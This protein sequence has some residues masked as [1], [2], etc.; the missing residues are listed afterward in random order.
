MTIIVN[1]RD[2]WPLTNFASARGSNQRL[3]GNKSDTP[4]IELRQ[5]QKVMY[6]EIDKKAI[7]D[8]KQIKALKT[9]P[10]NMVFVVIFYNTF[11]YIKYH[12]YSIHILSQQ[13]KILI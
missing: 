6:T 10:I 13:Y 5:I 3:L 11:I 7:S 12:V 2:Q 9:L 4:P 1:D 8:V